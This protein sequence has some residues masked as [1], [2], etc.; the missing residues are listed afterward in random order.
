MLVSRL[1]RL[2]TTI[3][4]L[5]ICYPASSEPIVN[6]SGVSESYR[7]SN[8]QYMAYATAVIASLRAERDLERNAH[9]RTRQQ[10]EHRITELEARLARRDAELEA[11]V[12]HTNDFLSQGTSHDCLTYR[13]Q[14][15]EAGK[16]NRSDNPH[17]LREDAIQVMET[18]S[19]KNKVLELEIRSLF[20]RVRSR[21][22][23][24]H[25]DSHLLKQ[26]EKA[27]Q[28]ASGAAPTTSCGEPDRSHDADQRSV[29]SLPPSLSPDPLLLTQPEKNH[30]T[31]RAA[32]IKHQ[33]IQA[34]DHQI[35]VLASEV[36]AFQ[37]ERKLLAD[38][39][40]KDQVR[41]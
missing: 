14:D 16:Q 41:C 4:I 6:D 36:D 2:R 38:F 29:P 18:T 37:S 9:E 22:L 35:M 15:G 8:D 13:S 20:K 34:L 3:V 24:V 28:T 33:S 25:L 5:L 21:L 10:A 30:I 17:L 1:R 12:A 31:I 39:V 7:D 23:S 19:A 27:R 26:L 40:A 11:C 32:D